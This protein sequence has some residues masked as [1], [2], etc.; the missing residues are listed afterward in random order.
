VRRLEAPSDSESA[1]MWF[2]IKKAQEAMEEINVL[3]G[4]PPPKKAMAAL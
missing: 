1:K 3:I 4:K 2:A